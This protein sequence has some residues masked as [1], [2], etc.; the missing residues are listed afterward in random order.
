[1][2][3]AAVE[4]VGEAL[5]DMVLGNSDGMD[6]TVVEVVGEVPDGTVPRHGD[7]GGD[8][9]DPVGV[10][11][12]GDAPAWTRRRW[13]RRGF[14]ERENLAACRRQVQNLQVRVEAG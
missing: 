14:E 2:G 1:V 11:V 6:P 9:V 3:P 4:A 10:E 8:G 5:D 13:R 7:G 12:V